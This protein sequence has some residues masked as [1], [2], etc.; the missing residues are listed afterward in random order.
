MSL[1]LNPWKNTSTNITV[2][3]ILNSKKSKKFENNENSLG[4]IRSPKIK[5][6]NI[7]H[8]N[9]I[10]FLS[11]EI[12]IEMNEKVNQCYLSYFYHRR[13]YKMI[14]PITF[15]EEIDFEL[16]EKLDKAFKRCISLCICKWFHQS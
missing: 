6:V 16:K 2:I 4:K 5:E 9:Y 14:D 7:I 13:G 10:L 15:E 12:K 1:V 11:F 3:P 8:Q